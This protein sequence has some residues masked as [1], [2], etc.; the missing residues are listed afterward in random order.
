[1]T[2]I[3]TVEIALVNSA[4]QAVVLRPYDA[5]INSI[6]IGFSRLAAVR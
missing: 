2:T 5:L 3:P 6:A 1:M 4:R